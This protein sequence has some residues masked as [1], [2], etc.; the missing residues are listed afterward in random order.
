MSVTE[1]PCMKNPRLDESF[2]LGKTSFNGIESDIFLAKLMLRPSI[3][4]IEIHFTTVL[5][6]LV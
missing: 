1:Q 4:N 5:E 6:M 2:D 3:P